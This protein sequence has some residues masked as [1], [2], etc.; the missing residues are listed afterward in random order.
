MAG[1]AAAIAAS[2]VAPSVALVDGGSGASTL[3][4]GALDHLFWQV[5]HPPSAPAL[6]DEAKAVVS[7]LAGYIVPPAGCSLVTI[8]G[9]VRRA[10]GHGSLALAVVCFFFSDLPI[11]AINRSASDSEVD[12]AVAFLA[13]L[14]FVIG[15]LYV[16][17]IVYFPAY[18]MYFFAPRYAPLAAALW[19]ERSDPGGNVSPPFSPPFSP[20]PAPAPLG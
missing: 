19:P 13:A 7:R 14:V 20:P 17:T 8:A 10:D 6:S 1:T 16:P 12:L 9:V 11:V 4:T 2:A 3:A 15:L 5:E 18:A